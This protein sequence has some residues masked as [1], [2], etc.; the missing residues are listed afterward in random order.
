M[1]TYFIEFLRDQ[2]VL[3]F[4]LV[5]SLGYLVGNIRVAGIGLGSVGGGWWAWFL[6]TWVFPCRPGRRPSVSQFSFFVSVTRPA[7]SSSTC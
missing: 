3:V 1:L 7:H 2:P 6:A 5:L 4:F